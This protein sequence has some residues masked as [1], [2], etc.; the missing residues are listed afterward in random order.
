MTLNKQ[1]YTNEDIYI[2]HVPEPGQ[3]VEVRRRLW[4]VN[5][6]QGSSLSSQRYNKQQHL[7]S[8]SSIDEDSLGEEIQVIWQLEA[9][10]RIVERA[11]LPQ[12]TGWDSA[13]R[14]EGFLDA[15]RWG[16]ATNADRSFCRLLFVVE[17]LLKIISLTR[18]YVQ[19]TWLVLTFLLPT[20]SG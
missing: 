11:G 2:Y 14:L 13:D 17:S 15:V 3:L 20:M 7:I 1:N 8:L 6:V 9:G 10:A 19:L 5:Q 4:V 18:W 12:I 16:A